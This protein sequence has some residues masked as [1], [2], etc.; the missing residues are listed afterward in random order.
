[1]TITLPDLPSDL[2]G[3][4][5]RTFLIYLFLVVVLR[6]AGK[7][8][9]GQLSVLELVLVLVIANAVQNAMVGSNVTVWGGMA[10][11]VTLIATDRALRW[12]RDRSSRLERAFEGE[13]TLLVRDG[14]PLEEALRREGIDAE[15]L[16]RAL[17][18][19]GVLDIADVRLAVLEVDG[20]VSV[21]TAS[22]PESRTADRLRRRRR[23]NQ[24]RSL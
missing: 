23:P 16:A 19:H 6:L 18:E 2:L 4:V 10:A 11:V 3:V 15:E 17:R 20:T 9:L 21:I 5:L 7:K 12:L 13:P 1:V 8:E 24:P 14:K 22:G